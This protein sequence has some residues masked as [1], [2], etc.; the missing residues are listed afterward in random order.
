MSDS[1][2]NISIGDFAESLLNSDS[3]APL[4]ESQAP[5]MPNVPGSNNQIDISNVEVPDDYMSIFLGGKE[6]KSYINNI[7]EEEGGGVEKVEAVPTNQADRF[8]ELLEQLYSVLS[9]AKQLLS[10]M[11]VGQGTNTVGT[12]ALGPGYSTQRSPAK[13]KKKNTKKKRLTIEQTVE[14]VLRGLKNERS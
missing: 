14:S 2:P 7:L 1:L 6:T 8:S 5:S 9:E 12:V 13:K 10:E 11:A 4:H 3:V